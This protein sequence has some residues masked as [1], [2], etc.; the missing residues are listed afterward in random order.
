MGSTVTEFARSV[1]GNCDINGDG[2]GEIIV[3]EPKYTNGQTD[4]GRIHVFYGSQG[5]PS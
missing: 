2:Y 3:R 1:S 5:L 4:E